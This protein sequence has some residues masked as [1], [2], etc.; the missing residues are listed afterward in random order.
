MDGEKKKNEKFVSSS[1]K[2][3]LLSEYSKN[4]FF[5]NI[6]KNYVISTCYFNQEMIKGVSPVISEF[7]RQHPD[8][9]HYNLDIND[10][11]RVLKKFEQLFLGKNVTFDEDEIPSSQ[12]ITKILQITNFQRNDDVSIR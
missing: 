5:E 6:P 11:E 4:S 12:K 2:L 10:E 1:Q 3:F 8:E 7:I 9:K